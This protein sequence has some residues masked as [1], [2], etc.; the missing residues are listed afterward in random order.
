MK[1][2]MEGGFSAR[3]VTAAGSRRPRRT[4]HEDAAIWRERSGSPC[5]AP[6]NTCVKDVALARLRLW[7]PCSFRSLPLLMVFPFLFC[8]RSFPAQGE[9]LRPS[10]VPPAATV[11]IFAHLLISL[12]LSLPPDERWSAGEDDHLPRLRL[13][14]YRPPGDHPTQRHSNFRRGAHEIGMT[15]P[16]ALSSGKE[17]GCR[18]AGGRLEAPPSGEGGMEVMVAG[19]VRR[20]GQDSGWGRLGDLGTPLVTQAVPSKFIPQGHSGA[21]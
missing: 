21:G 16:N 14:L 4:Q 8:P 12:S 20:M 3:C 11:T 15:Y 5:L 7:Q 9:E 19:A 6:K 2:G 13:R 1:G 18:G 10:C 17:G